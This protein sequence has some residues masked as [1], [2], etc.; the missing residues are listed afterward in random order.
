VRSTAQAQDTNI[1]IHLVGN[2]SHE[3]NTGMIAIYNNMYKFLQKFGDK[4]IFKCLKV[5]IPANGGRA[6]FKRKLRGIV[7]F[8]DAI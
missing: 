6:L 3:Y 7:K 1:S 5:Y 2:A 4:Y 8:I